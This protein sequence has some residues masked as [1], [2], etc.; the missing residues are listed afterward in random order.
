[1]INLKE[2]EEKYEVNIKTERFVDVIIFNIL[3][4]IPFMFLEPYNRWWSL[5]SRTQIKL[6]KRKSGMSLLC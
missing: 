6:Q 1:M 4:P 2:F 5:K 3:R